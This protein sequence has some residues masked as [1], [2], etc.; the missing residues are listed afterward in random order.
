MAKLTSKGRKSLAA[1]SFA[2]PGR[3]YPI[4]D[5]AHARNALARAAQHATPAEQAT[6]RAKVHKRFPAMGTMA[7]GKNAMAGM[8]GR[9]KTRG[10]ATGTSDVSPPP[11]PGQTITSGTWTPP[12]SSGNG[13]QNQDLRAKLKAMGY[14]KGTPKVPGRM[15]AKGGTD[16]VPAMLTPGEAVVNRGA[17]KTI[18]RDAIAR[19]NAKANMDHSNG[20]RSGSGAPMSGME[21]AMASHAD[22]CHPVRMR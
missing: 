21:Q 18:G 5:A 8:M 13:G 7:K 16:V 19:A 17:V 9:G 12:N 6:I 4:E 3:R 22:K 15:P 1:S 10:Y 2:L 11:A 14:V 20:G